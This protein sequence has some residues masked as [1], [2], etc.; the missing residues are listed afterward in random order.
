LRLV[1]YDVCV[2]N[3]SIHQSQPC[4]QVTNARDS[5]LFFIITI[6]SGVRLSLLGTAAS[7]G[8]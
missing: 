3:K 7:I 4:L 5:I 6:P 2:S 8:L 1:R